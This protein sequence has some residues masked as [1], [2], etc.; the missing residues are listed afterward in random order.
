MPMA[1]VEKIKEESKIW[2]LADAKH[3]ADIVS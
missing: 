2:I 3:L 1:V